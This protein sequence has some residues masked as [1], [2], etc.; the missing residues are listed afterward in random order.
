MLQDIAILTGGQVI[1]EEVGLSLETATLE[2][3][4]TPSAFH[5]KENT[6][7]IDGAGDADDIRHAFS[8]FVR[9][10]K[11]QLLTTTRENCRSAW[12]SWPAVLP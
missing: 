1:S 9:K 2:D 5:D 4:G 10:S 7:I 3:L 11:N 8:K 6:T 12:P